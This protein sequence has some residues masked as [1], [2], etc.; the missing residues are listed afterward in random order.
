MYMEREPLQ[1]LPVHESL[2][3]QYMKWGESDLFFD[4]FNVGISGDGRNFITGSYQNTFHVCI[5]EPN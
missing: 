3:K 2:R 1:V 4:R 5:E